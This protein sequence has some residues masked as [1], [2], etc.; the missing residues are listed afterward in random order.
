MTNPARVC[1]SSFVL[2]R[3]IFGAAVL[4]GTAQIA[5]LTAGCGGDDGKRP[6]GSQDGP[7]SEREQEARQDLAKAQKAGTEEA[8]LLVIKRHEG[9]RAS[10]AARVE[11]ARLRAEGARAELGKGNRKKA[12]ELAVEAMRTGDPEVADQARTTLEQIDQSDA[13]HAAK[14]VK[15]ILGSA[16]GPEECGKALAAV[17]ETL[18]EK[19]SALLV[20]NV[21][22]ET[23]QPLSGCLQGLLDGAKD[24]ASFAAARKVVASPDAKNAVGADTWHGISTS[25]NDKTVAAM[26]AA[27]KGDIQAGKWE[28][29]FATIKKWGE[30]GAADQ[31]QVEAASQGAR[32]LITKDLIAHGNAGIGNAKAQ[33]ALAEVER[34]L[35]LFEGLNVAPELKAMHSW[36]QGWLECKRLGCTMTG[37][38]QPVFTLGATPVLPLTTAQEGAAAEML[39]NATRTWTLATGKG[40]ALIAREDPA[41]R[42]SWAGRFSVARG[43]VDAASLQK[44][45]TT[46]WVPMGK[47]LENVRVW[48][49]SGHD[50]KLY[51]LGVVQSVADKD[52]T[53]K[54]LADNQPVTVKRDVLRSGNLAKGLKVLAFCTDQLNPT[55]ARFEEIVVLSGVAT[56]KVTCV[57]QDGADGK[58]LNE[59]LGSLRSKPEWLPP[60]KP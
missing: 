34:G 46:Y 48:L 51:L 9:T 26:V 17:S 35:K 19:P 59:V 52:V 10:E 3:F 54:K 14:A 60:R 55:E 37:K 31:A 45:D 16:Q 49:P 8:F 43:W 39:P 41:D 30:S 47:A 33:A 2:R 36:L 20:R 23:L 25:F 32:D 4:A 40:R 13:R 42:L 50:D 11:I 53:V 57:G 6:R 15:E 27:T 12:R 24:Q 44:E 22:K 56:A 21:R 7:S 18:G 58:T 38:P 5:V 29:A 1:E 28:S